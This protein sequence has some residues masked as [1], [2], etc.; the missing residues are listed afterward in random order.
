MLTGTLNL[1]SNKEKFHRDLALADFASCQFPG[2]FYSRSNLEICL[3]LSTQVSSLRTSSQMRLT[4]CSVETASGEF[5]GDFVSGEYLETSP[6]VNT[7]K[8]LCQSRQGEENIVF[9]ADPV[10][11]GVG[12]GVGAS[13]AC[14]KNNISG[15]YRWLLTILA[16]AIELVW[17][18]SRRCPDLLKNCCFF[19]WHFPIRIRV[20]GELTRPFSPVL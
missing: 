4:L 12:V 11:V 15:T 5:S 1:D 16:I 8:W 17:A 19:F 14:L 18:L 9:G 10:C 7:T 6:H 13:V 2:E 20:R 3:K